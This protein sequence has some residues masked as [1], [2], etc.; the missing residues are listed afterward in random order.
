[1]TFRAKLFLTALAAAAMAVLVASALVS[2]S[3]RRSLEQRIERE[4]GLQARMAAEML[5]HHSAASDIEL[6]GE[7]DA[8]RKILDA[9][10]TFLAGDGRV[11]GDSDLTP[12]Q[13]RTVEN[14]ADRPEILAARQQ[15]AGSA[16]RHSAT[17]GTDMMYVA[18]PVHNE[19]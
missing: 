16:Q 2:W 4:L 3:V 19:G 5:S 9:R 8:L 6:D 12:E 1:M 11:I 10:V 14:H 15:G 13:L 18:I 17:V 7:A